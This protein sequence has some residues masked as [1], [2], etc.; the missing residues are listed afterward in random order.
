MNNIYSNW[1]LLPSK[2]IEKIWVRDIMGDPLNDEKAEKV[3][4]DWYNAVNSNLDKFNKI[5]VTQFCSI[6]LFDFTLGSNE[7][8]EE[9]YDSSVRP[10]INEPF[11]GN[12]LKWYRKTI[13]GILFG[14]KENIVYKF[15]EIFNLEKF[16]NDDVVINIV[17]EYDKNINELDMEIVKFQLIQN[18]LLTIEYNEF[19]DNIETEETPNKEDDEEESSEVEENEDIIESLLSKDGYAFV[20]EQG[21][22]TPNNIPD[23][24]VEIYDSIYEVRDA[25]IS[26]VKYEITDEKLE[27]I[28]KIT[29]EY[30]DT[31]IELSKRI[32][33][34]E[35]FGGY[36]YMIVKYERITLILD[37]NDI[38]D[39]NDKFIFNEYKNKIVEVIKK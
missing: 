38:E 8:D 32:K 11:K 7:A 6:L 30:L 33:N 9:L 3:L 27:E 34:N 36:N 31:L 24:D 17:V 15:L 10:Y 13:D 35:I 28:K 23:Y 19:I 16:L 37:M 18:E 14:D 25:H 26:G 29:K 12:D 39:H 1:G 2:V 5:I 21:E 4:E 22:V 20:I